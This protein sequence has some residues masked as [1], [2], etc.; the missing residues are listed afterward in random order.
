MKAIKFVSAILLLGT[1]GCGSDKSPVESCNQLDETVCAR[2]YECYTP[3]ALAAAGFPASESACVTMQQA[4]DGC[5]AK[6]SS[7]FCTAGNAV[8][9]G[10]AVDGCLNQLD[11]LTCAEVMSSQ[12]VQAAAPKCAD[13]CVI[14]GS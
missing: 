9:H 8:F 11:G 2:L 1:V 5:A 10:D 14:P 7:N 4:A 3:A 6:T 13:I 12:N